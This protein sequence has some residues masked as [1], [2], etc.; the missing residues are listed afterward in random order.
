MFI[1]ES[2]DFIIIEKKLADRF[3]LGKIKYFFKTE[4]NI[5]E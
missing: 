3:F 4:F 2:N 1:T 5:A